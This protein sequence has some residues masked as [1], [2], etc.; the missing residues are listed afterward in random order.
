MSPESLFEGVKKACFAGEASE[1]PGS[2]AGGEKLKCQTAS[3]T[4]YSSNK[5]M[6]A[7]L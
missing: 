1:G 5:S 4:T 3:R 7:Y 2:S 6:P